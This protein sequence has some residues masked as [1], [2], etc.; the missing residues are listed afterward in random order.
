MKEAKELV[1]KAPIVLKKGL[2]KSEADELNEKLIKIGCTV[3]ISWF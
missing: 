2:V 1:E 3:K